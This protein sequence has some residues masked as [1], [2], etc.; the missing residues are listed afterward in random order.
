MSSQA[1]IARLQSSKH[2]CTS[3]KWPLKVIQG[4][5]QRRRDLPASSAKEAGSVTFINENESVVLVSQFTYHPDSKQ[6]RPI[7]SPAMRQHSALAISNA[8]ET[9]ATAS[10]T[11]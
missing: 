4:Q 7:N 3:T 8:D 10:N 1:L 9:S 6:T 2:T 5:R 11:Q